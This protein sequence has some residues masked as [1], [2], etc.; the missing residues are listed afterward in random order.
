MIKLIRTLTPENGMKF[1]DI[2]SFETETCIGIYNHAT[3]RFVIMNQSDLGLDLTTLPY[4]ATLG[5]L[6]DAVYEARQEHIIGVSKSSNYEFIIK[7]D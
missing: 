7:E 1:D 2:C 5:E 3:D 6:D 4:C